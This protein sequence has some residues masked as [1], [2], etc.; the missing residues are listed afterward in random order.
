MPTLLVTGSNRGLGFE[1]TRQ[2]SAAGWEV[3]ATCR[4][5][6]RAEELKRLATE[7][8]RAIDIQRLDVT[9]PASVKALAGALGSRA[10]DVL[11]ANAGITVANDAPVTPE[12]F[13]LV[14][15]TNAL[16][17]WLV[18]DGLADRVAA[19]DKRLM[20]FISSRM[21]SIATIESGGSIL[22]RASKAALNAGMR[23]LSFAL[24]PR[25]IT[26]IAMHPGWVRTDMG[27]SGADLAVDK[28]VSDMM[29][30]I[31]RVTPADSGH[32]F[33]HSGEELPW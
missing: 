28:S 18:A 13:D 6:D 29:R 27:G 12:N 17:P 31:G 15:H 25:R 11:I 30:V 20:V 22:Y 8:R 4:N 24:K 1:F 3:I 7:P 9:D 26:A 16:G 21:G 19:S 33:N 14:M 10:I 32:L 23:T 2:Y 5:P